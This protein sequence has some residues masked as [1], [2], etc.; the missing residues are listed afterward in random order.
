MDIDSVGKQLEDRGLTHEEIDEFFA[1]HG[2]L[3]QKWGV[4]RKGGPSTSKRGAKQELVNQ[5]VRD[6]NV[7]RRVATGAAFIASHYVA[8][9]IGLSTPKTVA[10][11]IAGTMTVHSMMKVHGAQRLADLQA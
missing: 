5:L 11:T 6:Q 8:K 7:K 10:A 9:R 2:V 3:G 4:R 1:H